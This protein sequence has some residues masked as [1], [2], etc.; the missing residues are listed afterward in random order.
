MLQQELSVLFHVHRYSIHNLCSK[1]MR[2]E[3]LCEWGVRG[4]TGYNG[5]DWLTELSGGNVEMKI[6]KI[7]KI[8]HLIK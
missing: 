3:M 8:F 7:K 5:R 1:R 2:I 6:W 4:R